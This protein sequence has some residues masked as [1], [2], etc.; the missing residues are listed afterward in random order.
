MRRY[1]ADEA[2]TLVAMGAAL[3]FAV[4]FAIELLRGC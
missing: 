4:M 2:L 3:G 1:D